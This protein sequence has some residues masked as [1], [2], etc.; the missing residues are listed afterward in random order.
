MRAAFIA[1]QRVVSFS[2]Q[3]LSLETGKKGTNYTK[4]TQAVS[5]NFTICKSKTEK[6]KRDQG[7]GCFPDDNVDL[8]SWARYR[9]GLPL[10]VSTLRETRLQCGNAVSGDPSAE[11]AAGHCFPM[12]IYSQCEFNSPLELLSTVS[13]YCDLSGTFFFVCSCA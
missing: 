6:T 11:D 2:P 1:S 3:T 10:T 5:T 7:D 9:K 8:I 13:L 12:S 4:K